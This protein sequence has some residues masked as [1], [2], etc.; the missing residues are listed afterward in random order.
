MASFINDYIQID[1]DGIDLLRNRFA[2][3]HISYS[4]I[5]SL[6]ITNGHLLKNRFIPFIVG[7]FSVIISVKLINQVFPLFTDL[8]SL[9]N[10]LHDG[11]GKAIAGV[12][13]L[14][15]SLAAIGIY[16]FIQSFK[17]S[18]ILSIETD[19]CNH[20]IRI[21]EFEKA[22][23]LNDLVAFLNDKATRRVEF[24]DKKN[25]YYFNR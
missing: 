21:K 17:V 9:S 13:I 2:Y 15:L 25:E 23:I 22:G 12:M 20:N 18:K 6:K 16:F 7:I 5:R 8:H 10:S 3:K 24:I 4:E 14:P 11:N 19:S 1:D